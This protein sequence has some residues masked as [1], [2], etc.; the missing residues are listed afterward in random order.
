M[1][2]CY[3]NT[4]CHKQNKQRFRTVIYPTH[5]PPS[6]HRD[7]GDNCSNSSTDCSALQD[8]VH[9]KTRYKLKVIHSG[10]LSNSVFTSCSLVQC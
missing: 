10:R 3:S 4:I 1:S 9:S 8:E 5:L 2:G 6:S 7:G